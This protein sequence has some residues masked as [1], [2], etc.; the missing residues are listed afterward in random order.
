MKVRTVPGWMCEG[1]VSAVRQ[2]V[3]PHASRMDEGGQPLRISIGRRPVTV[4]TNFLHLQKTSAK[5][6]FPLTN[7]DER[8][9]V[10]AR[11]GFTASP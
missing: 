9:T 8:F 4:H 7:S 3:S 11:N 1:S 10:V 6:S 5:L 2:F